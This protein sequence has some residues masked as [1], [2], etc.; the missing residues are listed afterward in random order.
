MSRIILYPYNVHSRGV[1]D[2]QESLADDT[3]V[4]SVLR[5]RG[6][7]VAYRPRPSDAIINWGNGSPPSTWNYNN[8]RTLNLPD[9]VARATNKRNAFNIF[10]NAELSI[11]D[12]TVNTN[13]ATIWLSDGEV[14]LARNILQGH[15]G[16]GIEIL[17]SLEDLQTNRHAPLFVKYK[18]KKQEFRVHV[19]R[20]TVLAVQEKRRERN[21]ERDANES[22]IRSHSNGWVFCRQDITYANDT[23]EARLHE[24][25]QHAIV[26]L[27]LDFGAVDIIYN[28]REDRFY[29]LEVNTAPGLEGE[30][31]NDYTRAILDWVNN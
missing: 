18:K 29:L 28:Q 22:L 19:F 11:P 20:G 9:A 6:D 7:S 3:A 13:V 16:Q 25:A 2:L 12:F 24:L 17:R 26:S 27:G 21:V 23:A 8:T 1:R 5:V 15:S 31:L 30:T 4:H 14:V 10:M